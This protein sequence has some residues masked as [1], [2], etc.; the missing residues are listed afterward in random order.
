ML[1]YV[2]LL[3]TLIFLIMAPEPVAKDIA[4]MTANLIVADN[5]IA[6]IA[7]DKNQPEKR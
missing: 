4:D 3:T 6:L 5:D 1:K 2:L 7:T